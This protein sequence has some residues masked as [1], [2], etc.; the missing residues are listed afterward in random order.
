MMNDTVVGRDKELGFLSSALSSGGHLRA[1]LVMGDQ[2]MGKTALLEA[3]EKSLLGRDDGHLLLSPKV[4]ES[5][6]PLTFCTSLVR[7]ARS[8]RG[9]TSLGLHKFA[10]TWGSRVIELEKN[11]I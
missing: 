2:G 1:G 4:D 3:I 11:K 5:L 9:N 8:G 10:R 7:T 6:D